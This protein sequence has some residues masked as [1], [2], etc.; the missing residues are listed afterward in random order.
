MGRAKVT[1][2]QRAMRGEE[3]NSLK[4]GGEGEPQ[5]DSEQGANKMEA[6]VSGTQA[7]REER[8]KR[9]EHSGQRKLQVQRP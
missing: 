9:G 2:S 6:I 5:Q 7:K 1:G 8:R 4:G 3:G